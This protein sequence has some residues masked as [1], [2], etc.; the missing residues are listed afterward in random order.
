MHPRNTLCTVSKLAKNTLSVFYYLVQ[1]F[2]LL[3]L[4]NFSAL[5]PS[6]FLIRGAPC[7]SIGTPESRDLYSLCGELRL[8]SLIKNPNRRDSHV[9]A[10][11]R[12]DGDNSLAKAP[13]PHMPLP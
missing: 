2:W 7:L 9:P 13:N 8:S 1:M 11:P 10:H 12:H 3:A 5:S 4:E 6:V